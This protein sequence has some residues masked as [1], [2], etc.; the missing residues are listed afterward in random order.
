MRISSGVGTQSADKINWVA[1][2]V[3]SSSLLTPSMIFEAM[4][5]FFSGIFLSGILLLLSSS[6][7]SK[8]LS[9]DSSSLWRFFS[10]ASTRRSYELCH[11]HL[12]F[13]RT[14][15]RA[16]PSRLLFSALHSCFFEKFSYSKC[17]FITFIQLST[18]PSDSSL[19]DFGYLII[20]R[21]FS[22][23]S[24]D[25][26]SLMVI[27]SR[28]LLSDSNIDAYIVVSF[29][30]GLKSGTHQTVCI[31]D[32][33]CPRWGSRFWRDCIR[34]NSPQWGCAGSLFVVRFKTCS[35]YRRE[36]SIGPE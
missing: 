28:D 22:P 21:D 30:T 11:V 24:V 18:Q 1:K 16:V 23:L 6:R 27:E 10:T 7:S 9:M 13:A 3:I 2:V 34:P 5:K 35:Q 12:F 14:H 26:E 32:K 8:N 19:Y 29:E 4:A 25:F 15:F 17:N 31:K 20:L 33:T 36:F